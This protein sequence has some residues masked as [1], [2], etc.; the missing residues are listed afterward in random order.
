MNVKEAIVT[1]FAEELKKLFPESFW[2][3]N[4]TRVRCDYGFWE[5]LIRR[6]EDNCKIFQLT[7]AEEDIDDVWVYFHDDFSDE[8]CVKAELCDPFWIDK[9]LKIIPQRIGWFSDVA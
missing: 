4:Y 5:V 3:Y 2:R 8:V 6:C 9:L 1:S 7:L